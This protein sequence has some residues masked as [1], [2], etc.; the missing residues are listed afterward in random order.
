M[1]ARVADGAAPSR[2]RAE[3]LRSST[4]SP[5]AGQAVNP[6]F[7]AHSDTHRPIW[8]RSRQGCIPRPPSVNH[9]ADSHPPGR[10]R[11]LQVS[12]RP[13]A[14]SGTRTGTGT[15]RFLSKPPVDGFGVASPSRLGCIQDPL[16]FWEVGWLL[17]S[18]QRPVLQAGNETSI[19][20][21]MLA[22]TLRTG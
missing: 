2:G 14:E 15:N 6:C 10:R 3:T 17:F 1:Q 13:G 4:G 12:D 16:C 22:G 19:S 7:A 5:T 9:H 18:A 20:T 21:Q 11:C 8:R